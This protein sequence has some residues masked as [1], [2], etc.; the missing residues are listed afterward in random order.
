MALPALVLYELPVPMAKRRWIH[1][2]GQPALVSLSVRGLEER[3]LYS[4]HPEKA[5]SV[6]FLATIAIIAGVVFHFQSIRIEQV[7]S[8]FSSGNY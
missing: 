2:Y 3:L 8:R 5:L 6:L 4:R 1:V 7:E